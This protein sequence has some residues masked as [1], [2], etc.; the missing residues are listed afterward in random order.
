MKHSTL[1]SSLLAL[2]LAACATPPTA[3]PTSPPATA[4]STRTQY[5][6]T[7]E[8]C[9]GRSTTYT[10]APERVVTIDPSVTEMLLLLGLDDRIVGYTEFYPPEGQWAPVK[11][12]LAKLTMIN[13]PAVGYPSKEAIVAAA[14]DLVTSVYSYA[15]MDPLPDR[16]G[17]TKLGIAS[18]ETVGE[19]YTAP[20]TDFSLLYRDLRN[21]GILFDVQTRAEAEITKL[22]TRVAA[23]QQKARDA[24]RVPQRI[25]LYDGTVDHP[26][27]YGGQINALIELAGASYVWRDLDPNTTGSWEQFVEANPDVLWIV[28]DAGTP[29][30]DLK[31]QLETDPRFRALTAVTS[32]AYV[33]VP[34]A[35]ATIESPRLVDG[36]EQLIDGFIALH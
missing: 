31:H 12:Q 13:D 33:I 5:P 4:D 22:E 35:D 14:P 27:T 8:D 7:I 17:W 25:A 16:D 11:A 21:F 9:G 23:L 15:F 10:K 3:A 24:G 29:V 19:C 32:K 36:L 20:P 26:P 34:Q 30:E 1:L 18:Y 2:S 6:V 28:P